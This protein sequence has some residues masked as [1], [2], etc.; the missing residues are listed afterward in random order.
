MMA[1]VIIV[2]AG[3]A[4]VTSAL[5]LARNGV[6]VTLIERETSFDRV[7][8]GEALMPLGLEALAQMG[9]A[10]VLDELPSRLIHSWDMHVANQRIFRV[11][12]PQAALGQRAVRVVSQPAFLEHVVGLARQNPS[13]QLMMG[14]AVRDLLWANGRV[15]GVIIDTPDGQQKLEADYVLGCDGRGSI[16]RTRANIKLELLPE[17]YDVLWFKFP[18]PPQL[19]GQTDVMFLGS[20]KYT[21]LCYNSFDN[22][23]RYALLLPKGRYN[24]QRNANWVAAIAEPSPD[25]LADYIRA[26]EDT[27]EPPML[28]NVIVGRAAQWHIPGLLLL[29]DAAH[30]MSPIRAQGINLALRDVVVMANQLVPALS[31]GA[32]S[33]ALDAAAQAV[34]AA[35]RPEIERAQALQLRE[36]RGQTNERLRPFLIT[37]ARVTA[38]LMG[39]FAWAQKAWLG[40]QHDLRFGTVDIQLQV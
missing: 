37:L 31:S 4:G 25:W 23:M 7:F 32:K 30:P 26:I 6:E 8:R 28:L 15:T 20:V 17:S 13:F 1:K 21:A 16:I 33:A 29:G 11:Y 40:Q 36:A 10:E 34:E 19:H 2:G 22:Q 14:T 12:E 35:R 24:Q 18:A 3:P 38:P 9:L 27:I 39:R 5:L